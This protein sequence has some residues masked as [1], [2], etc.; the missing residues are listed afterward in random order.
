MSK[1]CDKCGGTGYEENPGMYWRDK[2]CKKCGGFGNSELQI[3][4][5]K[6]DS[7][8]HTLQEY[9]DAKGDLYCCQCTDKI[10]DLI[11]WR[12]WPDESPNDNKRYE[13]WMGDAI[14]MWRYKD[15]KWPG[16]FPQY[17]IIWREAIGPLPENDKDN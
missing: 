14:E 5:V 15:G 6:C 8:R 13:V 1:H 2:C 9:I 10:R 12:K 17:K 7:C 4:R 16:T 11:R 3:M